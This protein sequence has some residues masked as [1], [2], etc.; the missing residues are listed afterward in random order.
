[1]WLTER[2]PYASPLVYVVPTA[3]MIVRAGGYVNPSGQVGTPLLRGWLFPGSNLVDVVL[4]MS[5]F[6]GNEPPLYTK[7]PG[8]VAPPMTIP[9]TVAQP[10]QGYP[11]A[12]GRPSA[13]AGPSG[14]PGPQ[15]PPTSNSYPPHTYP[16]VSAATNSGVSPYGTQGAGPGP[17]G[18]GMGGADGPSP[19]SQGSSS[20]P[21]P[22]PPGPPPPLPPGGGFGG[23]GGLIFGGMFGGQPPPPPPP[24]SSGPSASGNSGLPPPPPPPPVDPPTPAVSKQELEVGGGVRRALQGCSGLRSRLWAVS[25]LSNPAVAS[26]L[27]LQVHFRH[28]AVQVRRSGGLEHSVAR[29]VR[30]PQL[31]SR[32][33]VTSDEPSCSIP[34]GHAYDMWRVPCTRRRCK[35]PWPLCCGASA[36]TQPRRLGA[37]WSCRASWRSGEPGCRPR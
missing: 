15:P 11:A 26:Y 29:A 1:M 16:S 24:L 4:E 28:L 19:Y 31:P 20:M 37:S 14:P 3:S 22:P 7:P 18:W 27:P 10:P 35:A 9:G 2:Y 33:P 34:R 36:T 12:P 17:G 25:G 8:Y 32:G 13:A 21:P 6:F 23:L 5:R 30:M